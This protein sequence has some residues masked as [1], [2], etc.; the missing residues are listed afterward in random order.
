MWFYIAI[1]IALSY[2]R[3]HELDALEK[4]WHE[5]GADLQLV[6]S[7]DLFRCYT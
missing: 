5:L 1:C 6:R 4:V 2:P 3:N 7:R